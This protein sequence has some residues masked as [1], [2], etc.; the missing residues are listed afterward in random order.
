MSLLVELV[1][2]LSREISENCWDFSDFSHQ[3]KH[4][5][6]QVVK[7]GLWSAVL[8][9][10]VTV[11]GQ[12]VESGIKLTVGESVEDFHA[13]LEVGEHLRWVKAVWE[14]F[15]DHSNI[16]LGLR[17]KAVLSFLW[18]VVKTYLESS[19][20]PRNTFYNVFSL[21]SK[22]GRGDLVGMG[23]GYNQAES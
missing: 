18:F 11:L 16:G 3:H 10:S 15:Q 21:R 7:Y 20:E 5:L 19:P 8:G 6:G 23:Q 1:F 4:V 17:V 9:V 13:C 12:I 2:V 14:S 22:V